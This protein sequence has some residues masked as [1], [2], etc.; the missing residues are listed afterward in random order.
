MCKALLCQID[1]A[2]AL[3]AVVLEEVRKLGEE[4]CAISGATPL[5]LS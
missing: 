2:V 3:L 5:G 4:L 1:R